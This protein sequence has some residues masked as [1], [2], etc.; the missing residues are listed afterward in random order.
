MTQSKQQK[1]ISFAIIGQLNNHTTLCS[2]K[3]PTHVFIYISME[4]SLNFYKFSV[5]VKKE[6][7]IPALKIKIFFATSDDMLMS[8]FCV[9]KLCVLP[10]K[11]DI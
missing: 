5:S 1:L 11:T 7:S 8:Y 9:C 4:K 10:L 3:T 2:E 6:T